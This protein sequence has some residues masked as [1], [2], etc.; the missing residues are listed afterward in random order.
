MRCAAHGTG[1][2]GLLVVAPLGSSHSPA[3][4]WIIALGPARA[5]LRAGPAR[6]RALGRPAERLSGTVAIATPGLRRHARRRR[7]RRCPGARPLPGAGCGPGARPCAGAQAGPPSQAPFQHSSCSGPRTCPAQRRRLARG[8]D[9]PCGHHGGRGGLWNGA[10]AAEAAAQRRSGGDWRETER[11]LG[12]AR[13]M[14]RR[15]RRGSRS[16]RPKQH[17]AGIRS[18]GMEYT[19]LSGHQTFISL[20]TEESRYLF[21]WRTKIPIQA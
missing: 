14:G 4:A 13:R 17:R 15:G 5:T 9:R 1:A 6:S 19:F 12:G 20:P 18:S 7:V 21:M 10:A 8:K 2:P 16:T 3:L 11:G